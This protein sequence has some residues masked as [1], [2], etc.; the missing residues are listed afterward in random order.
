[1]KKLGWLVL[2]AVT[3][4]TA[5]T[6]AVQAG[7]DVWYCELTGYG[8]SYLDRDSYQACI[9]Q[10]YVVDAQNNVQYGECWLT[11]PPAPQPP[12]TPE[13]PPGGPSNET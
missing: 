2:L 3:A 11:P 5:R 6:R 4:I 8:Y 12:G 1:M 7:N 13:Q 9:E 10:C